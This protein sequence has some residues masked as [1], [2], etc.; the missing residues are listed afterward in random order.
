MFMTEDEGLTKTEDASAE[1]DDYDFFGETTE[2][3]EGEAEED[4][5]NVYLE[6]HEQAI[7][8][9]ASLLPRHNHFTKRQ[10]IIAHL[11]HLINV[12][13]VE[14]LQHL[15]K[16]DVLKESSRLKKLS[17]KLL[18]AK[19]IQAL[20]NKTV[21][22]LGGRF[23]SGKSS[24]INSCLKENAET[25]L[26]PENQNPTT[27]I[28][29]YVVSGPR[30]GIQ[31]YLQDGWI[32]PLQPSAMQAMTH[33]F[34]ETYQIG[35]ARFVC[36]L[37]VYTNA[38]PEEISQHVALLDTP[39]YNKADAETRDS[40][41]DARITAKQLKSVDYLIWLV[42]ID[43]GTVSAADLEFLRQLHPEHP[44]LVVFNH[45]DEKTDEEKKQ[46]V[47][48]GKQALN[49]AGIPY[50]DA[51]AYSSRYGEEYLGTD[52]IREFFLSVSEAAEHQQPV[53]LEL[54]ELQACMDQ[55]YAAEEKDAFQQLSSLKETI[56]QAEDILSILSLLRIYRRK[57]DRMKTLHRAHHAFAH[58]TEQLKEGMQNLANHRSNSE[59]QK[60]GG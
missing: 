49:Q 21:V 36:S 9:T 45:A 44:L 51:V 20:N 26:L 27:S 37:I 25:V 28:P 2:D 16:I 23:S 58:L 3:E 31:A 10:E 13:M 14:A 39:G 57:S 18:A 6:D 17:D 41:S 40:I 33:D 32:V 46:V 60:K 11:N 12:R 30:N 50:F 35:F 8:L 7:K 22:G 29:T 56:Y 5:G 19:Q 54:A 24:F 59:E 43:N 47:E 55:V 15:T 34:Y 4:T 38:Y 48:A 52:R 42:H 53:P 1:D